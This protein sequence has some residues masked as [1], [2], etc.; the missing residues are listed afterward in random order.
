M[1]LVIG[2]GACA[3]LCYSLFN[4]SPSLLVRSS[5]NIVASAVVG[6]SAGVAASPENALAQ[7]LAAKER[8]LKEREARLVNQGRENAAAPSFFEE[9][10]V[11]SFGLSILL[12]VLLAINYVMD[13]RRGR[14]R[15]IPG[16]RI[17]VT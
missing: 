11:Y 1:Y 6:M 3:L 13:W 12:F 2:G 16:T 5:T 7:A 17:I 10:A 4:A 8:E 9:S 14:K 15:D